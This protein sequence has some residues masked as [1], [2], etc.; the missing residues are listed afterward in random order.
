[1]EAAV[2]Y[3]DILGFA[4]LATRPRARGALEQ[5]SDVAHLLSTEDSLAKYLQRPV[6]RRRYGLSDSIFLVGDDVI[7][8]SAAAAA[9]FF[10]LA[11]YNATQNVPALMRGAITFGEVR[12]TRG[13]FPE[14]GKENVVG[15]AVIRAVKLERS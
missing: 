1:M 15:E 9:F 13:I 8:A 10:N 11:F 5:L 2:F 4:Q 7:E 3:A 14:T 6:W 12:Q